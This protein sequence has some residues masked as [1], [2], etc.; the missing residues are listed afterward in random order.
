MS[1]GTDEIAERAVRAD[2]TRFRRT[3]LKLS[4]EALLGAREYGIDSRTVHAIG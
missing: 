4:G 2:G 3:L 1:T